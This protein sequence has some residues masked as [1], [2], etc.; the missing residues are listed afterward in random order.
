MAQNFV[1]T[2][3]EKKWKECKSLEELRYLLPH[4]IDKSISKLPPIEHS[5]KFHIIVPIFLQILRYICD[6]HKTWNFF[7]FLIITNNDG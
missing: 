3:Y 1:L 6:Q 7:Y 5:I 4:S 2:L